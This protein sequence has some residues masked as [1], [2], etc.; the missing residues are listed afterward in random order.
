MYMSVF[1]PG[2]RIDFILAHKTL[3]EFCSHRVLHT[4]YSDH[5]PVLA[6]LALR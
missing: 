1:M 4:S 3:V 6:V 2:L 5:N